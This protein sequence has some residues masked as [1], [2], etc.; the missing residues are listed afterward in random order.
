MPYLHWA[1]SGPNFD[2]RNAVIK[3]LAEE[4]K[5]SDYE[6][7]SCENIKRMEASPKMR[8][9]RAFLYPAMDTCLHIRRTLDQYYYSTVDDADERTADQVVYKFAKK[10]HQRILEE[11]KKADLRRKKK[12]RE[13]REAKEMEMKQRMRRS[14]ESTRSSLKM[15][16]EM[17]SES[18]TEN[19][20]ER[21][22]EPPWDPPKVMMVNQLWMWII[23]GGK[24]P[25]W[26]HKTH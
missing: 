4:F 10:Q 5:D 20:Y 14:S 13:R 18:E 11:E 17:D 21:K 8:V 24:T 23:D 22:R 7:P 3:Q 9:L 16:L 26:A 1:T 25:D 19:P 2:H 12:E 6:R 15:E